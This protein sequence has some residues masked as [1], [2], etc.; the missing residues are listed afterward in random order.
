VI[1]ATAGLGQDAFILSSLGCTVHCLERSPVIAALLQDGIDRFVKATHAPL[2]LSLTAIDAM[3]YL[4]QLDQTQYPDVIYLDPM[5]PCRQKS[6]L[7]KKEMRLLRD[8]VGEDLDASDLLA[9]SLQRAKK[10]VV[11]KRSKLAPMMTEKEP[12]LVLKGSSSR[13]DVYLTQQTRAPSDLTHPDSPHLL[14]PS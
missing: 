5:F 7:V 4:E 3:V 12:D 1:D 9:L 10:R 13:F 11:V 8:M 14:T 6:A 2:R